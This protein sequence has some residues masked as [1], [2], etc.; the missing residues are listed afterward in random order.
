MCDRRPAVGQHVSRNA[1]SL[2]FVLTPR[3]SPAVKLPLAALPYCVLLRLDGPCWL[4]VEQL[5]GQGPLTERQVETSSVVHPDPRRV[6]GASRT[7]SLGG[8]R[9]APDRGKTHFCNQGIRVRSCSP[10]CSMGSFEVL[11]RARNR[12]GIPAAYSFSQS[13]ANSPDWILSRT[14]F[15]RPFV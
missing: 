4:D 7:E 13:R 1:L 8:S 9:V 3:A 11:A 6:M 10:T 14:A 12:L 2:P 15:M 5:G